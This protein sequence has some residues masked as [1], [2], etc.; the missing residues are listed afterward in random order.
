VRDDRS[1]PLQ[2]GSSIVLWAETD[3]GVIL[4]ADAIG[5]LGKPSEVVGTEAAETLWNE[6]SAKPTVDVH[7]ADMLV[8]YFALTQ[9]KS[10]YL[11]RTLTEHLSTNIWL[12]EAILRREFRIRK[13]DQ[14]CEI[15]TV[16]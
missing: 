11:T 12:A 2:K 8:P 7:L 15:E 10:T 4:G 13:R 9:G 6:L 1:N 5:E 14:L 3:T 16:S